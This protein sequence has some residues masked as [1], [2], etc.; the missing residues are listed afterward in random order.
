M[1]KLPFTGVAIL[2]ATTVILSSFTDK[3]NTLTNP[4]DEFEILVNFLE[5]N[6]FINGVFPIIKADEVK[7]NMKNPNYHLIDIRTDSWFEYGHIK[8][9]T[10][11]P[12]ESLLNYFENKIIPADYE[13][14]IVICYS[15]QSAA[16]Y[17][18]LLRIAGYHNVYSMKWG[19]SSW[20]EDFAENSWLKN[21]NNDYAS[22]LETTLNAKPMEGD[23]PLI[24]TGKLEVK[25]ILNARLKTYFETPY[26]DHIVKSS[27]VFESPDNYFIINYNDLEKYTFGHIP[28]A[29]QYDPSTSFTS[30]SDLYTLPVDKKIVIYDATGQKA[31]YAVAYLNVLGYDVGNLAYGENSFMN[32]LMKEKGWDT[33][34]KKEINMYPVIE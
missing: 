23:H 33:F 12:A 6:N 18:S 5:T 15:G 1:K 24:N 3:K 31:A 26:K 30:S 2:F 13:K 16:Y 34:S 4:P 21:I 25:D 14:I 17:V 27:D 32:N 29:V 19:M 11:V 9:A 20:R 10:N 8:D 7:K 22:K 28:T